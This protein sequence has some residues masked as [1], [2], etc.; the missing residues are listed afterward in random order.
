MAWGRQ[1]E[2]DVLRIDID[3]LQISRPR[4]ANLSLVA[5]APRGLQAVLD[6]LPD[7]TPPSRDEYLARCATARSQMQEKLHALGPIPGFSEALRNALPRDGIVVTDVTQLGYYVRFAMP[8][9]APR[10]VLAPGYQATLGYALPAALGA[11]LA[12]PEKKVVAICGDGGFMFT[13]QEL[14][15][16]VH[17]R[18]PVVT[19]VVDNASYGNV[20]AIQAQSY[21]ARH[22]AVELTNPDF[23][24]MAR[25]Y[26]MPAEQARTPEQFELSLRTMLDADGPVL[27]FPLLEVSTVITPGPWPAITQSE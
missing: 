9:Y 19:V 8:A 1:S 15:T 6:A 18:I 14:A 7:S 10:T 13:V 17:H 11:K 5:S 2:V 22:I 27:I 4:A 21:G 16:A 25:S 3:P 24:E 12:C 23:V 26:G 20:K